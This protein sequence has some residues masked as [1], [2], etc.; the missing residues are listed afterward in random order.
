M[1]KIRIPITQSQFNP[2]HEE[3]MIDSLT[4]YDPHNGPASKT[5]ITNQ[6]NGLASLS[7]V[8]LPDNG[9]QY[10]LLGNDEL[11]QSTIDESVADAQG[12]LEIGAKLLWNVGSTFLTELPKTLGYVGGAVIGGLGQVVDGFTGKD[13]TNFMDTMVNNSF[14]NAF[15]Q[16]NEAAKAQFPVHLSKDIQEGGL[17]AKATSGQ[18]WASTGADGIGFL[19]SMMVPGQLLK[20]AGIGNAIGSLGEAIG[21]ANKIAGKLISKAGLIGQY[22]KA[23]NSLINGGESVAAAALNTFSESAAEAANTFDNVKRTALSQGKTEEEANLIA[24]NSAAGVFKAN[25]PLLLVSNM[26]DEKWLWNGFGV[27]KKESTSLI[28]KL[29]KDGKLDTNAINAIQ[30]MGWKELATKGVTN[31]AKEFVKEGFIE[32]G[33]QTLLQQQI[34]KSGSNGVVDDLG[35]VY[36][37]YFSEIANNKEMQESVFLGGML[38]GGMSAVKTHNE[39]KNFNDQMFGTEDYTPTG[40]A[41]LYR[42]STVKS[43]GIAQLL[44]NNFLSNYKTLADVAQKDAA[45]NIVYKD[46][47]M[48]VDE[49]KLLQLSEDKAALLDANYKYDL[50]VATGNDYQK[51]V[52]GNQLSMN[53]FMPFLQQ[54][55]GHEVLTQHINEQLVES[56]AQRYNQSTGK[57][58]TDKQKNDY[59]QEL[60]TKAEQLN[61]IYQEVKNTHYPERY[62]TS[63]DPEFQNWKNDLFYSKLNMNLQLEAIKNTEKYITQKETEAG[64]QFDDLLDTSKIDVRL[65][66]QVNFLKETKKQI[67]EDKKILE[68]QYLELYS[69]EGLQKS[70]NEYKDQKKEFKERVAENLAEEVKTTTEEAAKRNQTFS[71]DLRQAGYDVVQFDSGTK[72]NAGNP[73]MR[74]YLKETAFVKDK[75]GKRYSLKAV[76]DPKTKQVTTYI[77]NEKGVAQKLTAGII[78]SLEI[79]P[80]SKA[81]LAVEQRLFNLQ[82]KKQAQLGLLEEIVNHRNNLINGKQDEIEKVNTQLEALEKTLVGLK[83]QLTNGKSNFSRDELEGLISNTTQTINN[84]TQRKTNLEEHLSK[85]NLL[86]EQYL[87]IL[88]SINDGSVRS[89]VLQRNQVQNDILDRIGQLET[90]LNISS[91]IVQTQKV[92]LAI[93]DQIFKINDKIDEYIKLRDELQKQL[94]EDTIFKSLAVLA[95]FKKKSSLIDIK[96]LFRYANLTTN[97]FVDRITQYVNNGRIVDIFSDVDLKQGLLRKAGRIA[98]NLTNFNPQIA[99]K[100]F[101]T[102]TPTTKDV[103]NYILSSLEDASSIQNELKVSLS[104]RTAM[105]QLIV[106][107]NQQIDDLNKQ[108]TELFKGLEIQRINKQFIVLEE[109]IKEKTQKRFQ[110]ILDKQLEKTIE[111][112]NIQPTSTEE[113]IQPTD[114]YFD[115]F[116]KHSLGSH[117]F[118]TTGLHILY[119]QQK[120]DELIQDGP[121]KGLPVQ[122]TS[123][124]QQTWFKVLDRLA[125]QDNIGNYRIMIYSPNYTNPTTPLDIA[126]QNNNPNGNDPLDLFAVLVDDK[127]NVVSADPN[128]NIIQGGSIP[129]FTSIWKPESLFPAGKEPRLAINSLVS[130]LLVKL[131]VN[132]NVDIAKPNFSQGDLNK[133]RTYFNIPETEEVTSDRIIQGAISDAKK[134]YTN[135]YNES[136]ANNK[137]GKQTFVKPVSITKGKPL[138]RRNVE[139]REVQWNSVLDNTTTK[140]KPKTFG[141]KQLEGGRLVSSTSGVVRV[142]EGAESYNVKVNRGDTVLVL[143]NES[144]V[145]QLKSRN[146]N[147]QEIEVVMYLLSLANDNIPAA[148]MSVPLP[149]GM[150]FQ[151]GDRK[152]QGNVPL[153]FSKANKNFSLLHTLIS[154]GRKKENEAQPL[155]SNQRKGEIYVATNTKT[156]IYYDW[157]GTKQTTSLEDLTKAINE[158]KFNNYNE[159]VTRLYNFLANKRFN[160]SAGLVATN[161][162]FPQP[163][164]VKRRNTQGNMIYE[165]DWTAKKS[166]YQHLLEGPDAVLTTSAVQHPNYPSFVQRNL[167][168]EPTTVQVEQPVATTTNSVATAVDNTPDPVSSGDAFVNSAYET[169]LQAIKGRI[170]SFKTLEELTTFVE[171]KYKTNMDTARSKNIEVDDIALLDKLVQKEIAS[172]TKELDTTGLATMGSAMAEDLGYSIMKADFN[173]NNSLNLDIRKATKEQKDKLIKDAARLAKEVDGSLTVTD[174]SIILNGKVLSSTFQLEETSFGERPK[175]ITFETRDL[176][177][178]KSPLQIL[179]E[180]SPILGENTETNVPQSFGFDKILTPEEVLKQKIMNNQI[181]VECL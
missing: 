11:A 134:E 181:Q 106:S 74:S 38:G 5:P 116:Y 169:Q 41:R 156:V 47:K 62:F 57:E 138:K 121:D 49:E 21:G 150:Y 152:I 42:S 96:E 139:N 22:G 89:I 69:K 76:I 112:E 136:V 137:A 100:F 44:N 120:N 170:N 34:E 70:F 173:K 67:A 177:K 28:S 20:A 122:N 95:A 109:L 77:Y 180:N 123:P 93:E 110:E 127:G 113:P 178:K 94:D 52:L 111:P 172:K 128:G 29:L 8:K 142:G 71:E 163:K 86:N 179:E 25:I 102:T 73:I 40:M 14:V 114:K 119:D 23:T 31:F 115:E 145:L 154:Y 166:Y 72:D 160:I 147:Q 12:G 159:S 141:P 55:G 157:D 90:D 88:E 46:G 4:G 37:N 174:D 153:L 63:P 60:L 68:K 84:L 175:M 103:Y 92:I 39:V 15:E 101:G 104:E 97:S 6:F 18:W 176:E 9:Q 81:D 75:N 26:L 58:A 27:A 2:F 7:N 144:N 117:L 61:T 45:G 19:L 125:T 16:L 165:L 48:V 36:A 24:G 168:F 130:K 82:R 107:T 171:G 155:T 53:Y 33:S 78:K 149:E 43:P 151:F 133:I 167:V 3:D 140:L 66:A 30:K 13:E 1:S 124:Y 118:A 59:K 35:R 131:R 162:L 148:A 126:I 64:L 146:I 79:A 54:E 87:S 91:D 108:L 132:T 164:L 65:Q 85:L 158:G 10:S 50:A 161:T 80:I 105:E 17:L 129:V 135:W 51:E 99:Q 143:D 56:W 83:E 98:I 32:E